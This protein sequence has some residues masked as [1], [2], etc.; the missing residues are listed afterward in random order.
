MVSITVQHTIHVDPNNGTDHRDCWNGSLIC[1]SLNYA[2]GGVINDNTTVQ[3]SSGIIKLSTSNTM[4]SG[5]SNFAI[6]GRGLTATTIQ[7]NDTKAGLSFIRM[8]NLTMADL[9]ITNCGMLQNSTTW[10]NSSPAQY[11]SAVT[12]YNSSNVIIHSVS[13]IHNNGIGLSMVNTGGLVTINRS[14]FDNNYI[15]DGSYPGGGGLY[16]EYPFC[17]PGDVL[18]SLLSENSVNSNSHYT[19]SGCYFTNNIAKKMNPPQSFYRSSTCTKQTF[20]H[21]G[22]MS[23]FFRGNSTNNN[24]DIINTEFVGNTA[25]WGGGLFIEF[26]HYANGNTVNIRGHSQFSNNN[27]EDSDDPDIT[28]GGGVQITYAPFNSLISPSYNNVTFSDCNFTSN[29]AFWGGG[30]SYIITAEK[31]ATGTN[32]LYFTNCH[33]H[34]NIAKFGAAVDLSLYRSMTVGMAQPVVFESCLFVSNNVLYDRQSNEFQLRGTGTVYAN[35]IVVQLNK[36][37]EFNANNGSALVLSDSYVSVTER[38]NVT[39]TRNRSWRG[40]ALSLL[41]SSWMNIEGN[42]TI[43]FV[44]NC[45]DEVGGAIY[46]ELTNEH[47]V[48]SEW[49]C[50]IQYSD[51]SLSPDE[52]NTTIEFQD[53]NSSHG[54]HSIYATTIRSCVWGKSN[55]HVSINDTKNTFHWKAFKFNGKSG[56][57]N[58]TRDEIATAANVLSVTTKQ[59]TVTVSPGEEYHLPFVQSDDEGQNAKAIFFTQSNNNSIGR[60]D[61]RSVYVYSDIMQVYGN[62]LSNVDFTITSVGPIPSTITLNITFDYCPPGYTVDKNDNITSCKCAASDLDG[63]RGIVECNSSLF[64]AYIAR[65]HWGGVYINETVEEFVT[66]VCPQGYC[67]FNKSYKTILPNSRSEL[68]FCS[69]QNRNGTVCGECMSGYS[70]S[71]RSTCIKCDHGI[72]KG[73]FLF[74]L[75]ECLP[76]LLFVFAILIFNVNITSGHWNSFI[77]YFQMVENL[78]LYALQS[79][80]DYSSPIQTLIAIHTNA[81]GIWNLEFFQSIKPEECYIMGIKNV[82]QLYLLSYCILLFPLGLILIIIGIKNCNYR[83]VRCNCHYQENINMPNN[84]WNKCKQKYNKFTRK[85]KRWFGEAS[86]IHGFA[87]FIVLSYTNVA[88]LSMKFFVP[89]RLYGLQSYVYETRTYSVGTIIYFSNEHLKYLAPAFICLIISIYFPCYLIF[90]PLMRKLSS[91]YGKEEQCARCDAVLC[92]YM[93]MGRVEQLLEEF[94]GPFKNNCRFYAGFFFLYRLAIYT[95]LAFTPSL[96]IQYCIQQCILV[97][98]LFLHSI[99]QPYSEKYKHA[100]IT[101]AL[102]FLNL[103][104]I[105]ALSVYNF[106]SVIDIQNESQAALGIQLFL[107]YLPLFYIPFRFIWWFKKTCCNK[108]NDDDDDDNEQFPLLRQLPVVDPEGDRERMIEQ[109]QDSVNINE[110]VV[111]DEQM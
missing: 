79:T 71:S 10:N 2:L 48:I 96:Q 78:N 47:N 44:E 25:V 63:Y 83:L 55:A 74:I 59:T 90:K 101:D 23:V 35:S 20:G 19:I 26:N 97:F 5:L 50:F 57:E 92:C 32:S 99:L 105:N 30:V 75:Y 77:F 62:P 91:Y 29:S 104:C 102:I 33:W 3:L 98:I 34:S 109:F 16:I 100:N 66:A 67:T 68:D 43:M 9:T 72:T 108:E 17:F 88:L 27:C 56:K 21:G 107:V 39:F 82:F 45:A 40:G 58:F 60:V 73:I 110:Y 7:C 76:T 61:N 13:F 106:Y 70:I 41:A 12:I 49:N 69:D 54:G 22:G 87:A 24:I 36:Q 6:V 81:F 80:D 14:I 86:L 18:N 28:G 94:Y 85:W 95:T 53:N 51:T 93:D 4:L 11:P 37:I 31:L 42:T 38:C 103:N 46:A 84:I 65:L 111:I 89:N 1:K 52:W 8:T 64:Q 15:I